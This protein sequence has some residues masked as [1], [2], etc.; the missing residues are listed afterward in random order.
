[1]SSLGRVRGLYGENFVCYTVD[2]AIFRNGVEGFCNRVDSL[3]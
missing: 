1:M 3:W 2:Y